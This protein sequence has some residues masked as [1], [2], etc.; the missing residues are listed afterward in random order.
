MAEGASVDYD[1]ALRIETRYL[2]KLIVNPVA[3]NMINTFFFNMNAIKSGQSR[4]KDVPRYKPQK[5]GILGDGMMGT[6]GVD[7]I[8][9]TVLVDREGKVIRV[10]LRGDALQKRLETIFK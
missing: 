4:P 3:K 10:G 2:A 6:Y 9:H 1:R 8:P 7:S 5:V